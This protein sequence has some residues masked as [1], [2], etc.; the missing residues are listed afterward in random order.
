MLTIVENLIF[1]EQE[2]VPAKTKPGA[3]KKRPGSANG[4]LSP[5]FWVP[6]A[7]GVGGAAWD[8]L[9]RRLFPGEAGAE[10]GLPG[11][12]AQGVL[13]HQDIPPQCGP[14]GRDL[15]QHAQEGLEA[16]PGH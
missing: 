4:G 15:C 11:V 12:P 1:I 2:P 13:P 9:Q 10:Q 8:A 6:L 16:G 3:G 7:G 14:T 5:H